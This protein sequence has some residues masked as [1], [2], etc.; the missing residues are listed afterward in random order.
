MLQQMTPTLACKPE[1]AVDDDDADQPASSVAPTHRNKRDMDSKAWVPE[2]PDSVGIYHAFVRMH[3]RDTR[4]H[5]L[6]IVVSGGCRKASD[7][8][9]NCMLDC[10]RDRD[11][12]AKIAATSEE[13]WWLRKTCFRARCLLAAECAAFFVLQVS[14]MRDLQAFKGVGLYHHHPETTQPSPYLAIPVIDTVVNDLSYNPHED[15]V[16]VHSSC[17]DVSKVSNGILCSMHPSEVSSL[18]CIHK[19][20]KPATDMYAGVLDLQGST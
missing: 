2:L 13:T 15:T 7:E 16:Q 4:T 1:I 6:F 5:K 3:N 19:C 9:Y 17:V 14:T 10:A 11:A 8:F 20:Q 12:T 18:V